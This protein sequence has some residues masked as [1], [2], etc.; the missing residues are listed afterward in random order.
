MKI[1]STTLLVMFLGI[2]L[3]AQVTNRNFNEEGDRKDWSYSFTIYA[4]L[5]SQSTDVGTTQIRQSFGDLSSIT[6]AGFQFIASVRYKR[7]GFSLDGTLANLGVASTQG[8]LDVD[9]SIDQKILDFKGSYV[10]FETFEMEEN[11]VIDGWSIEALGGAKYWSNDVTINYRFIIDDTPVLEDQIVQ[12]QEWWDLMLG[13]KTTISL[14]RAVLLGA[15]FN[16]GGF[17]LGN[18][19]K[20]AYD[21]TYLNAFRVSRLITVNAG[22]R[23]FKYR[24]V[25]GEGD[26]ELETKVN[27]LGPFLGV[28]FIFN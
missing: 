27:V 15:W 2:S 9:A 12:P 21:L 6:D 3:T 22:F 25:D 16:V 23:S 5:A 13:V 26:A 17:G 4:L 1:Y 24:R 14:S 20:F 28:S 19:S 11:R 7:F 8:P 10:V 18:S